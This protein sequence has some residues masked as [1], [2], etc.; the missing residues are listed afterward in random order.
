M[1][2]NSDIEQRI[3]SL[4]ARVS[5]LE[6]CNRGNVTAVLRI[7]AE[8]SAV[9]SLLAEVTREHGFAPEVISTHLRTRSNYFLDRML[10]DA[11]KENPQLGAVLDDRIPDEVPAL[12]GFPPLFTGDDHDGGSSEPRA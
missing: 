1:S 11:E 10:A 8:A 3:S 12:D 9:S 6:T 7:K 5:D 4:E 2:D